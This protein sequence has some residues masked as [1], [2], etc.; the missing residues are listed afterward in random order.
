MGLQRSHLLCIASSGKSPG[1]NDRWTATEKKLAPAVL[2]VSR[3]GSLFFSTSLP[4]M[5][6]PL[7]RHECHNY[8]TL[9]VELERVVIRKSRYRMDESASLARHAL[10]L[11]GGGFCAGNRARGAGF[12]VRRRT[13]WR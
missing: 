11:V 13:G 4:R 5:N 9:R 8:G 10:A 3:K 7:R 6:R 1:T 12:P 2:A